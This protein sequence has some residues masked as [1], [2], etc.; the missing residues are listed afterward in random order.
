LADA[1]LSWGKSHGRDVCWIYDPEI[2]PIPPHEP[3]V[4]EVERAHALAALKALSRA[5]EAKHPRLREHSERVA[6]LVR[7]LAS[8]RSWSSDRIE[9]LENAALVHDVGKIGVPDAILLKPGTL[10]PQE[11]DVIKQHASLGAQI[12]EGV[13]SEEQVEWVRSHHERPDGRGYPNGLLAT[14]LSEGA[15]LLALAD[16][17]DAMTAP[18]IYGVRKDP[19]SALRECRQLASRQFLPEAVGALEAVFEQGLLTAA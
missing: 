15:G 11:Y 12:V 3:V 10:T 16:A 6:A 17:F 4:A 7:R 19:A 13:L 1:A 5:I 9:L 18:R 8:I 2:V 14:S